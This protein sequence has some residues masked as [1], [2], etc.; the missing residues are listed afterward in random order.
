[1]THMLGIDLGGTDIKSALIT[2]DGSQSEIK[3]TPTPQADPTGEAALLKLAE[4]IREYSEQHA[5]DGVGLAVPGLVDNVNGIGL[6]S[7]T[8]GWRDLPIVSALE[9]KTGKKITLE[10]DVTAIGH[11][12]NRIGEAKDASSAVVIAIGTAIAA[13][14]IIDGEVY[15]PHPAVGEVGHT[16]TGNDRPCVCGLTGCLEMT[17][18]GGALSR[19]YKA[20]T[21]EKLSALEI[22]NLATTG[23]G[24]ARGLVDEFMD[25]LSTSLVFVSALIGPEVIVL[26]GGVSKAGED[27]VG[28]LQKALDEKL[29]IHKR[30]LLK[31]SKLQAGAGAIGAGLLAWERLN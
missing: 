21:G 16:P 13:S 29:S 23:N 6:Y 5:F 7:G 11:A 19:N 18:S 26:S 17:A 15:H 1:M 24:V 2:K 22:F 9:E 28:N 4:I 14:V 12:E 20:L 25:T 31:L 30:P 3:S 8:L 10:H 27:F